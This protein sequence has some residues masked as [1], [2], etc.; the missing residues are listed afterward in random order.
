MNPPKDA[1][2]DAPWQ[3]Q[4]FAM[5]VALNEAGLFSWDEWATVFGP[6]VQHAEAAAYWFI[7]SDALLEI[8]TTRGLADRAQVEHLTE[9]WHDAART[10]PHGQEIVLPD[11]AFTKT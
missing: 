9:A 1:P 10:T 4:L 5:T 8:L 7:W 3:A 6:K 2:F 11:R